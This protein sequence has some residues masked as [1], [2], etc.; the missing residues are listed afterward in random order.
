MNAPFNESEL[1][2]SILPNNHSSQSSS[3][4]LLIELKNK[5]SYFEQILDIGCGTGD[6]AI[7]IKEIFPD[8]CWLGV[9]LLKSP[10]VNSRSRKIENILSYNGTDLPFKNQTFDLIYSRQVFE[11]VQNPFALFSEISRVSKPRCK[12]VGS[13]SQM[14]PYHSYSFFNWTPFALS[15]ILTSSGFNLIQIR[16]GIDA[17]TLLI[18]SMVLTNFLTKYLELESPINQF[19]NVV[20]KVLNK[21]SSSINALKLKIAG[22]I[23][24]IAE[25]QL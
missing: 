17:F 8:I 18:R 15:Q 23:C 22:H 9:D 19:L 2:L 5:G 24:F 3:K 10:E 14:E 11:H 4:K 12:F 7:Y 25:K 13:V 20:G 6:S 16:P 21:K 1:P